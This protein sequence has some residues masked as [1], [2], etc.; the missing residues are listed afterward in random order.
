MVKKEKR[1]KER[2]EGAETSSAWRVHEVG[3]KPRLPSGRNYTHKERDNACPKV[4]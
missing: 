3:V 4:L 2:G 1:K